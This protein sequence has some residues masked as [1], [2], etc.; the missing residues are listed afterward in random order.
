[1]DALKTRK[2]AG[3]DFE[4][5][6]VDIPIA[7]EGFLTLASEAQ[8]PYAGTDSRLVVVNAS[9]TCAGVDTL[10]IVVVAL[11]AQVLAVSTMF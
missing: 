9:L 11:M 7:F 3:A 2:S 6:A 10:V 1:M 8:A 5:L 4:A